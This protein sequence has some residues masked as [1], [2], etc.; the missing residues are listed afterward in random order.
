[1]AATLLEA[2]LRG[3]KSAELIVEENDKSHIRVLSG[4]LMINALQAHAEKKMELADALLE[5]NKLL[6]PYTNH[7]AKAI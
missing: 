3:E 6:K 5:L 4:L 2:L 1:M 7:A